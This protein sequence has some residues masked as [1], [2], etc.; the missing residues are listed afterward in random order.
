MQKM[1]VVRD[2]VPQTILAMKERVTVNLTL[3]VLN[4]DG[5]NVEMIYVLTPSISQ[6]PSIPTILPGLDL[7]DQITAAT[8]SVI[9][10]ITDVE[11]EL[12]VV[13]LMKIVMMDITVTLICPY[14]PVMN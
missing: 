8:E 10:I 2:G 6:Q 3:T 13:K 5:Q 14:L 1:I 4:L 9:R 12:Q 11:M 7:Q